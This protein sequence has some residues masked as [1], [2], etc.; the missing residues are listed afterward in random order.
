MWKFPGQGSNTSHSSNL[1]CFSDN[2]R[3]L[4]DWATEKLHFNLSLFW[5]LGPH[6][7]HMEVPRLEV[8]LE[9]HHSSQQCRF[10]YT[11]IEA[12]DQTPSSGILVRLVS[13]EPRQ[14][15]PILTIFK[16]TVQCPWVHIVM[17]LSPP[18]HCLLTFYGRFCHIEHFY[19][20]VIK[21]MNMKARIR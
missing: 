17:Q 12:R 1:S 18:C 5:F 19:F 8:K 2:T 15:L 14:E 4:T 3:S 9:L 13:T 10:L 20:Y 16:G 21:F 7:M 6:L 11:L